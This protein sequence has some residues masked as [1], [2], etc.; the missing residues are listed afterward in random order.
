MDE[1]GQTKEEVPERSESQIRAEQILGALEN[2]EQQVLKLQGSQKNS[3]IQAR[4]SSE[5]D[6]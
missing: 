1:G 2:Q 5:K 6:W 3:R 4:R